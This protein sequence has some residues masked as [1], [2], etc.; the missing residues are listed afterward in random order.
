M[1]LCKITIVNVMLHSV[2]SVALS[3]SVDGD[4]LLPKLFHILLCLRTPSNITWLVQLPDVY[5]TG[6]TT[7]IHVLIYYPHHKDSYSVEYILL[8]F[9]WLS[10][11]LQ[12][13]E[14]LYNAGSQADNTAWCPCAWSSDCMYLAHSSGRNGSE[15]VLVPWNRYKCC[16]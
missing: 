7:I 3:A 4:Q 10:A 5:K 2:W 8:L 11:Q 6:S 16:L 15:V 14:T 12:I 1:K 9:L 13:T